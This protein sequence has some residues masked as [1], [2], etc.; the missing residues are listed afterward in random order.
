M[1]LTKIAIDVGIHLEWGI[2]L[3]RDGQFKGSSPQSLGRHSLW[4]NSS[5]SL[6]LE[7]RFTNDSGVL[8]IIFDVVQ[9]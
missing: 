6:Q 1:A 3:S 2:D 9:V 5:C 8:W 4:A 7:A